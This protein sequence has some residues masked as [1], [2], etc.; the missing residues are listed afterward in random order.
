MI[1]AGGGP[2]RPMLVVIG[3]PPGTGKTTLAHRLAAAIGCPAICRDEIKQGMA[4]AN[5][6]FVPGR[7]DPLTIRTLATFFEL[8]ALLVQR[9]VTV[10]AEAAFQDQIWRPG[11]SPLLDQVDLRIVHCTASAELA[12]ARIAGRIESDP[13]RR[14]HEDSRI[15]DDERLRIHRSFDPVSFPV[16]TLTVDTSAA[17]YRPSLAKILDFLRR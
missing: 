10:V 8:I 1:A 11:L 6:G 4:E 7:S 17:D 2:A 14:A 13:L 3:G 16:P 5:P 9:G 12:L 15:P